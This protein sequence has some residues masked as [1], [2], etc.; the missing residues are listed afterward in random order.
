M[1]ALTIHQPWASLIALGIKTIETRTWP[2]KYRG[3]LAIHAGIGVAD[4]KFGDYTS[5][6]FGEG[7]FLFGAGLP[8]SGYGLPF[9]AVVAVAQLVDVVPIREGVGPIDRPGV[10]LGHDRFGEQTSVDD[11]LPYGDFTSGRFAWVLKEVTPVPPIP[12][13]G[14]QGLW[15]WEGK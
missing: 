11:Q 14:R 5:Q 10:W 7:Y 2:T 3:E 1:K 6:K 8:E 4:G 12:A 13:K 15:N 9:G